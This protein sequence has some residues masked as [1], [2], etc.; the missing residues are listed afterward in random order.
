MLIFYNSSHFVMKNEEMA[1][2][3]SAL[4]SSTFSWAFPAENSAYAEK[5]L[6]HLIML[7]THKNNGFIYVKR[8]LL[9]ESESTKVTVVL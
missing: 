6:E 2:E 9:S 5:T 7:F 8:P 4:L 3:L 1:C